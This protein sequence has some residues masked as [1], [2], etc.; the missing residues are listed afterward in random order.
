MSSCPGMK[1]RMS[2]AAE[3][4]VVTTA[5][6]QPSLYDQQFSWRMPSFG[7]WRRVAFVTTND[8]EEHL[9][10]ILRVERI[11]KLV[12]ANVISSSQQLDTANI[13]PNLLILFT[14]MMEVIYSS[15]MSVL[16]SATWCHIPEDTILHSHLKSYI[17][18]TGWG[19]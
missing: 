4:L 10:S 19:L 6:P 15:E 8:S 16:T 3:C 13:V 17:A 7:M 1:T 2:P 9:P 14:M 5:I 12:T 11:S 18:L